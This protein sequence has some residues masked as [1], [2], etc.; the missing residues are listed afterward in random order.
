MTNQDIARKLQAHARQL[1]YAGDNL[2]RIRAF[3]QAAMAVLRLPQPA[4]MVLS[5]FGRKGLAQLAGI[6]LSTATAIEN[7]LREANSTQDRPGPQ[8]ARPPLTRHGE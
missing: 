5:R 6:G 8:P 1:A 2:Y 4:E 7:W 3:R